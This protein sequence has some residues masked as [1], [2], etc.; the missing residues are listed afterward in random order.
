[1][2]NTQQK[3]IHR[4][5][6]PYFLLRGVLICSAFLLLEKLPYPLSSMVSCSDFQ[7]GFPFPLCAMISLQVGIENYFL[8]VSYT[9]FTV[10]SMSTQRFTLRSSKI[11]GNTFKIIL[12][13]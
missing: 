3:L 8:L 10:C 4:S 5:E 11:R 7:E 1:M 2:R 6:T 13:T 9:A 12:V